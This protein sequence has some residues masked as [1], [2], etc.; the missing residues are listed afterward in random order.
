MNGAFHERNAPTDCDAYRDLLGKECPCHTAC[1][2]CG[3]PVG[4]DE[5]WCLFEDMVAAT[6]DYN[7][8]APWCACPHP[9]IR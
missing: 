4:T 9:V 2:A 3:L 5:D 1:R 8:T 6:G 7:T